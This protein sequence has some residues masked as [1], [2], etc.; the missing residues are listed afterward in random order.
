MFD[1]SRSCQ[2]VFPLVK[3]LAGA[4]SILFIE[5]I[6]L[7][8]QKWPAPSFRTFDRQFLLGSDVN[9]LKRMPL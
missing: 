7:R 5:K 3:S 9:P 8:N 1:R 6:V 2:P 4:L